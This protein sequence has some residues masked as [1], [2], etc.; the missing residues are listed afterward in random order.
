MNGTKLR[1]DNMNEHYFRY[2]L[3]EFVRRQ[4]E[5]GETHLVFWAGVPH[6]WVDQYGT[7]P[8]EKL[9]AR[10]AEAGFEIDAVVARPYNYTLFA[11]EDSLI[12]MHSLAYYRTMID[13]A[14]EQ[15]IFLLGIELWGAL[16]DV[17][18]EKQ[19]QNCCR[20]LQKL[21]AY[22]DSRKTEL[23]VG[24]VP[25][26]RS[27]MMNTLP[28]VRRLIGAVGCCNLSAALDYGTACLC[29]E[30]AS[31]WVDGFGERLRLIYLSDAR[32]DGGGYPLSHGCCA[33]KN[34]L[35]QLER[36]GFSGVVALR[37]SREACREDPASVDEINFRY[38]AEVLKIQRCGI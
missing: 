23:A 24:N 29:G 30:R 33:M 19:Y 22:A 27:A 21:C 11:E 35:E 38:L 18:R 26:S 4:Q 25:Y 1:I 7:E 14:V 6:L 9:F 20:N 5:R 12:D 8:H 37:M 13:L 15:G 16:R 2:P 34:D 17:D 3:E 31:D 10:M 32:N 36:R 28:E